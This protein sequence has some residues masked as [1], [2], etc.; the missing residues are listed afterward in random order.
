MIA[1]FCNGIALT[2]SADPLGNNNDAAEVLFYDGETALHTG[3]FIVKNG[4]K[5]DVVLT[6][7]QNEAGAFFNLKPTSGEVNVVYVNG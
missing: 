2:D 6:A 4:G 3:V 5:R 1:S 7:A